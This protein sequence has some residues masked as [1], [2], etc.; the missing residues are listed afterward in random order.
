MPDIA[1]AARPRKRIAVIQSC[2][3]PWKGYFDVIGRVDEFV[4]L[5]D[6]QF[7]KRDWRNRNRIKSPN[8]PLWLTIPVKTKGRFTQRIDETEI[9]E[10]WVEDHWSS[11]AHCY[12]RAAC[13]GRTAPTLR[14]LF[15]SVAAE[16]RLSAVNHAL[17]RG[18]CGLLGISTPIRWSTDYDPQG[19]KTDRLLGICLAAG[20]TEY[21]SG[22][23]ARGY[24]DVAKFE[25][26]GIGVE[27]MEYGPYAEYPQPHGPFEHATSIVDVLLCTGPDAPRFVAGPGSPRSV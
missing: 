9:A 12:S 1:P 7:T 14:A 16:T 18:V 5:D 13:F 19:T 17:L 4:L 20:A 6:A 10:P 11:I 27:W 8:G 3:V 2:Y 15:E 26:A 23:A 25:A 22:P 21:L 24:L